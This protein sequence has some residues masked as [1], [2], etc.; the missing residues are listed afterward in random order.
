MPIARARV[1]V[2]MAGGGRGRNKR[3][4][5]GFQRKAVGLDEAYR[6]AV[7][8]R[9][10][11]FRDSDD[12]ELVFPPG[13]NPNERKFIHNVADELGLKSK[14]RGKGESRYLT[15]SRKDGVKMEELHIVDATPR[16]ISDL[17]TLFRAAPAS[18]DELEGTIRP[19]VAG[20]PRHHRGKHHHNKSNKQQSHRDDHDPTSK[21]APSEEDLSRFQ[22]MLDKRASDRRF[23]SRLKGRQALPVAKHEAH[24]VRTVVSHQVTVVSGETGCGKS[25]QVPQFVLDSPELGP[26]AN[27]VCTQPRRVSAISLAERIAWERCEELGQ[28]VGFQIKLEKKVTPGVT[29]LL[30]CTTGILIRRLLSD[31]LLEDL[32]HVIV[33]EVHERDRNTDFLLVILRDI[34]PL[35]PHLRVILMSATIEVEKFSNYFRNA[36]VIEMEGFTYPIRQYFLDDILHLTQHVEPV[37]IAAADSAHGVSSRDAAK[38]FQRGGTVVVKDNSKALALVEQTVDDA[39]DEAA[40]QVPHDA[41]GEGEP[42]MQDAEDDDI[43]ASVLEFEEQDADA[44]GALR[45]ET[46]AVVAAEVSAKRRGVKWNAHDKLI[47]IERR[48]AEARSELDDVLGD[49]LQFED[50]DFDTAGRYDVDQQQVYIRCFMLPPLLLEFAC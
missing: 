8:K 32:T 42:G 37:E 21:P 25:T 40:E 12:P 6:I 44:A 3:G 9:L 34:L 15:V 19:P 18:K 2:D 29:Q 35:R 48:E 28:T 16:S 14:S 30:M 43:L 11:Q 39:E 4:G 46:A 31:P 7:R 36:P 5:R 38:E 10:E 41:E 26:G 33:D 50:Q 1:N 24:I 45:G 27:I 13:L 17:G 23:A 20:A 22:S 47:E 49:L